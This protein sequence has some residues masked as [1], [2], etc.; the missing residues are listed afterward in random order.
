MIFYLLLSFYPAFV[1]AVFE[2][3]FSH[4]ESSLGYVSRFGFGNGEGKGASQ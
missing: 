4:W 2:F 1:G 3:S